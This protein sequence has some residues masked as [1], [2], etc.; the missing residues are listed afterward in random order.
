MRAGHKPIAAI[1][2]HVNLF[3]RGNNDTITLIRCCV[4]AA[5]HTSSFPI[6]RFARRLCPRRGTRQRTE[7]MGRFD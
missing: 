3:I 2:P 1:R 6:F 5:R 4:P 7:R